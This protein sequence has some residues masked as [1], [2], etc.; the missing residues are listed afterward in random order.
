MKI[1][2]RSHE[3]IYSAHEQYWMRTN[4]PSQIEARMTRSSLSFKST[5]TVKVR[6]S[7]E[8]IETTTILN[9]DLTAIP[10]PTPP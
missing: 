1:E 4:V 2:K 8:M 9:M 5:E 10:K 3:R 6:S 7:W